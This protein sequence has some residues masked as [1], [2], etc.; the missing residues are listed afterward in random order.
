VLVGALSYLSV[1]AVAGVRSPSKVRQ[2]A[3]PFAL[4]ALGVLGLGAANGGYFPSSWGWGLVAFAAVVMWASA[5]QPLRRPT[6]L[7]TFYLGGLLLLACWF[8]LSSLWGT[9]P[10][11][12]EESFRAALY[13]A[14]AVAAFTVV[15]SRSVGALLGGV[16]AG[17]TGIAGYALA[18]RLFPST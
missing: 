9:A 18:T 14:A 15:R 3:P 12:L 2:S 16:L 5:V 13:V 7:E 17:V 6:R 10:V 4:G 8:A 11:A 1:D